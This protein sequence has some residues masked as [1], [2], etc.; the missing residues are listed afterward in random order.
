MRTLALTVI[1]LGL[2]VVAIVHPWV[3]VLTWTW[4]SLMSPHRLTFGF[5]YNFP[6]AMVVAIATLIGIFITRDRRKLTMTPETW[7]LLAFVGWICLTSAFAVHFDRIGPMFS[8]VMKIQFMLFITLLVL[9]SKRHIELFTWIIVLSLGFYGVKGGIYTVLGGGRGMVFGPAGSFIGG[10]NEV[11]LALVMTIPLMNYFR[12]AAQQQW[13]RWGMLGMMGL[14]AFAILGTQSRGAF[15]AIVAMALYLWRHS[16]GKIWFGLVLIPF[17][18][19]LVM[20]MPDAWMA[21][22]ESMLNYEQDTSATGRINSWIMAFNLAVARFPLGGGFE[23]ITPYL[24]GRFAPNPASVKAA[25]SIYFQVLGEHGFV[26][27]TLFLLI[28]LVTWRSANGIRSR[29]SGVD[30]LKWAGDLAAMVKV[31]LI[32]YGVGGAFL[33]LAYFDLAYNL[34]IVVVLLKLYVEE[35]LKATTARPGVDVPTPAVQL[36]SADNSLR[37][38]PA[39]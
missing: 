5:T 34:V 7:C 13:I 9:H 38:R 15:L 10:N 33:S 26:G 22:M 18:I 6:V 24:F 16:H 39:G 32:G 29:V 28:W 11:A 31:S 27:L 23:V 21:R 3:G 36:A 1:L 8:K 17:G 37:G 20:F 12:V 14:T 19:G 4:V 30:D 25:H 35:Q 2:L